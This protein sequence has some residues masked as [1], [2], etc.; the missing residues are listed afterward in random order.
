MIVFFETSSDDQ[1]SITEILAGQDLSF[2]EEKLTNETVAQAKDAEIVSVFVNS[3]VTK[4]IIDQLNA[5]KTV[6]S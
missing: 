4:E 3:E 1:K 2:V 6:K 5:K